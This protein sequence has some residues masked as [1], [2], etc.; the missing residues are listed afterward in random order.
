MDLQIIR[1]IQIKIPTVLDKRYCCGLSVFVQEKNMH[2]L[3]TEMLQR[4]KYLLN[5]QFWLLRRKVTEI[6][7]NKFR[8]L[9]MQ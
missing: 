5:L 9:S 6:S 1:T 2:I 8:T 4:N 3:P 7:E